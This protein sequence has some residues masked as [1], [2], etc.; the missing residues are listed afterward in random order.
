MSEFAIL[1][2]QTPAIKNAYNADSQFPLQN[3]RVNR[4]NSLLINRL[5]VNPSTLYNSAS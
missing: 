2:V 1:T 3:E 5:T 4:A